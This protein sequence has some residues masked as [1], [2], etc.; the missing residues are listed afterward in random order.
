MRPYRTS[1]LPEIQ[2]WT[3]A[4]GL[5]TKQKPS[6]VGAIEPGVAV[7][8]LYITDSNVAII[9]YFVSNPAATKEARS[10][11]LS[12]ILESLTALARELGF[13]L[14]W[15]VSDSENMARRGIEQG[16]TA[17]VTTIFTKEIL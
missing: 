13:E 10:L 1:D 5:Q 4:R 15:A 2:S 3:Q 6:M 9:D 12:A 11:A 8:F 14:L 16:W 7:G 17:K